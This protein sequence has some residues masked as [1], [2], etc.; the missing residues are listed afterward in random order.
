M[1]QSNLELAM[2]RQRD[3]W[4]RIEPRNSPPLTVISFFTNNAKGIQWKRVF[5]K[6]DATI[7]HLHGERGGDIQA[8]HQ[9][10]NRNKV[11]RSQTYNK[12]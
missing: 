7:V 2:A 9:T 11:N 1:M 6:N 12:S 3:Q 10:T 5:S 8:L 4:I